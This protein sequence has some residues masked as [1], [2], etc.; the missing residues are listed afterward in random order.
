MSKD[1]NF[2]NQIKICLEKKTYDN[3]RYILNSGIDISGLSNQ[4]LYILS[5]AHNTVQNYEQS[6]KII[7]AKLDKIEDYNLKKKILRLEIFNHFYLKNQDKLRTLILSNLKLGI[8]VEVLKIFYLSLR[9]IP[10]YELF[11]KIITKYIRENAINLKDAAPILNFFSQCDELYLQIL[12][13]QKLIKLHPKDPSLLKNLGILYFNLKKYYLAKKYFEKL[14][15]INSLNETLLALI[16]INN[17]LRN[18]HKSEEYLRIVFDNN[19]NDCLG[20]YFEQEI[21][22][23]SKKTE[24]LIEKCE[25]IIKKKLDHNQANKSHLKLTLSKLYEKNKNYKKSAEY[26]EKF[27][28]D[29]NANVHFDINRVIKES[30]FF[31]KNFSDTEIVSK[32]EKHSPAKSK[33]KP[34][35]IIG[36]PRSGTTLVEH[37]LGAHPN[38][39][40][41]GERN[42]FFKNF[43]FL[44]DIY[45]LDNNE[46][47]LRNLNIKNYLDYGNHYK[48]YFNLKKG[49]HCFTD[50]MPFNFLY[51]GLIKYTLPDAKIIFC[52][53]D[54]RDVGLSIYK[55]FFAEN[56]AFAY[57]KKNIIDYIQQFH[58]TIHFWSNIFKDDIFT[59]NYNLLISD[60]K[61]NIKKLLDYC[62]LP[63]DDS[64]LDF[65]KKKL[66]ADTVSVLQVTNPIYDLSVD[67]WKNYYEFFKDFFDS[68]ESIK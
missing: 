5:Y 2:I 59:I 13:L 44:F 35:F 53:R 48:N 64:C 11:I 15:K 3:L 65:H 24:F 10:D 27:N 41:F 39:Q 37:I 55:N 54:Y 16:N 4:D 61:N 62:E 6:N 34:I 46:K 20:L 45:N 47:I 18:K 31:I 30:D 66:I 38:V 29:L 63:W 19:P 25:L 49:K 56:I 52:K 32:I 23:S 14:L 21:D 60:P 50:K 12:I 43:K 28:H 22:S 8:D 68:L 40:H 26:I 36:L 42:F 51:V 33:K 7:A 58:K 9:N 57:H 67:S 17:I 1:Q